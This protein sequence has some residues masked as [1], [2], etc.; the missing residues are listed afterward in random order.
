MATPQDKIRNLLLPGLYTV[1]G[2]YSTW[3]AAWEG[4]FAAEAAEVEAIALPSLSVSLP[5]AVAI[6]FA[7]A[8]IKNP[9]VSRRFLSWF[10]PR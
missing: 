10:K 1:R 8:V 7:A 9:T 6:G 5:A 2:S 4:L 3:P